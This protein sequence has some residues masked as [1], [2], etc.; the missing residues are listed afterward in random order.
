[1][2]NKTTFSLSVGIT[3]FAF[4]VSLGILGWVSGSQFIIA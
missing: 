2:E 1:M 4:V 3:L